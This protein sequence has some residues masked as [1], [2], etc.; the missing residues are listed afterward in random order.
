M[1]IETNLNQSPFFDD[2]NEDKN[3]HRVLFRPGYAVQAR[4]L[5]QLQTILQNQVS[6][7]GS[8]VLTDGTVVSGCDL[9]L[10][11]WQYVKLRDKDANNRVLLLNDFY[12]NA[13]IANSTVT[14]AATGV[15]AKLLAVAEGSEGAPPNY[16][17]VFVSYTNSGTDN[18]TK[19][20]ADGE[21]LIFRNSATN[22][23]IVAANT[24]NSAATG[25]GIGGSISGGVVYH[26]GHFVRVSQQT[27][28]VSKYSTSPTLR[29]G[30]ETEEFIIDSNQ[31]SSLLDNASGATNFSAPGAS[32]LKISPVIKTRSQSSSNTIG[33]V[34]LA[35]I[36]S[37][38]VIRDFLD[39]DRGTLADELALRTREESGDYA[40]RPFKV[41]VEEHLKT[42]VNGGVYTSSESGDLNKLVVEVSPSV[43]YVSGYRTELSGLYREDID[44]AITYDVKKDVVVGQA[45]GNYAICNEVAGTWDFQGFREVDIYDTA[46]QIITSDYA[47]AGSAAGSKVGT[48]KVRGFQHHEGT[49]GTPTGKFRIYLF[50]IKM[51]SGQAFSDSLSLYVANVSGPHSY[52]DIVLETDG[53]AR[54]QDTAL[55]KLV[56]PI[57]SYGT[58]K[59]ADAS[60][61]SNTQYVFRTEKTVSF[62]TGGTAT[63]SANTAHAGGSEVNNDTGSPLS[64]VDERNI[65]IVARSEVSTSPMTGQVSQ[66]GT[67]VTG[68]AGA[69]FTTQ[70]IVGDFILITGETKQRIIN[71]AGDT[72]MNVSANKTVSATGH[73]KVFP[74]GHIFDTQANGTITSTGSAHS[75]DLETANLSS[76][77]AASVYFDV[78]RTSAVQADKTV[79]KNKFVHV[80]TGSHTASNAGPWPLGVSDAFRLLAVYSGGNTTVTTA[81]TNVTSEFY[82]ENGQRDSMY[83]TA[84]L[85]KRPASSLD[86]TDKGLLVKFNYF[87]RDRS[88]GIGFLSVDSYPVDDAN[89]LANTS[90]TTQE[91]PKYLSASGD[92]IDLRDSVD[93]RPIRLATATP[94]STG[95]AAAAPTNPTQ[96]TTFDIDSDG[97]YFPTPDQNFQ[98]DVQS[99]LPRYDRV[100]L[101]SRG[102]I[103]VIKGTPDE[104]PQVPSKPDDTMVLANIFVPPYPSL[105]PDAALYYLRPE[106]EVMINEVDNRRFTMKDLR[107]LEHEVKAHHYMIVLNTA[108]IEALKAGMLRPSDPIT[109]PE[110]PV[111]SVVVDPAPSGDF[112][113][114]M[115][116]SDLSFS[117]QPLRA[118]PTLQ[119]IELQLSSGSVNTTVVD[120]LVTVTEGTP[121][122]LISQDQVTTRLPVSVNTSTP[123]KLYNGTMRLQHPV[124]QL[125]QKTAPAQAVVDITDSGTTTVSTGTSGGSYSTATTTIYSSVPPKVITGGRNGC[126]VAGTMVYMAD[127]SFKPIQDVVIGD[128]V[129]SKLGGVYNA[130]VA[131]HHH[132]VDT[133][134]IYSINDELELTDSHPM[135][136]IDGWKSFNVEA[137]RNLHP[138]LEIAGQLTAGDIMVKYDKILG[139]Y[140]ATLRNINHRQETVPVYNL[141]VD[142]D[143]TFIVNGFAVHNK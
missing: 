44:K 126:F 6:R 128:V 141:D 11:K 138:D 136:T 79:N 38:R 25:T 5:T 112:T 54:L 29:V 107:V 20:F 68:S 109:A 81:D 4:E 114:T 127:D 102:S 143:D 33:F 2:F 101:S 41:N 34:P 100:V 131:V 1:T 78:L 45:F 74:V 104:K 61:N 99:Y 46:Q 36:Q 139:N 72:S 86:T 26:K 91:I 58:R 90:I 8:T 12:S 77:F 7:L 88:A 64:S 95:T 60:D 66:S 52:A 24:I 123:A 17:S 69:T 110:P 55:N 53:K 13:I 115:R 103:D 124:C 133:R 16:L 23:F 73:S 48:A 47:T 76:T 62:T 87:G 120:D 14:G 65:I 113:N 96:G 75:I 70:Y 116:S 98:A 106:S 57:Q 18:I 15:T 59:L 22:N 93:F 49:S 39:S 89:P 40:V 92:M 118:I 37:G 108:E 119:N 28:I 85:V 10:P 142:R 137:T 80:D 51:N 84:R 63:V 132:S 117:A 67:T 94:S 32:R 3:F 35:D 9:E 19:T 27:G 42:E 130:V 43:G 50:D 30:L 134:T 31:D 71:I 135:L 83:D 105:S 122:A 125:P 129:M 111:D 21:T 140:L 56:L 97:S 121:V 82:I